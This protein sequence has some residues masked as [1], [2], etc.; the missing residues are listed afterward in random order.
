MIKNT[1]YVS[2]LLHTT[3]IITNYKGIS[4]Y[5]HMIYV[6]KLLM[7]QVTFLFK[8][9]NSYIKLSFILLYYLLL[10]YLIFY[11]IN[12]HFSSCLSVYNG[13]LFGIQYYNIYNIWRFGVT[14]NRNQFSH[15]DLVSFLIPFSIS[16][17]KYVK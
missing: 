11:H 2:I 7:Q 4:S 8:S 15:E 17:H 9:L 12:M 10:V 13:E 5:G 6:D 16:P 14:K 1:L 3:Q